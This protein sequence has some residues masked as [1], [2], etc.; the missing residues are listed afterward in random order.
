MNAT[1]YRSVKDL[2]PITD[3]TLRGG[4]GK[5]GRTFWYFDKDVSYEFGYGLSYT[6]FEYSHFKISQQ[7][8]HRRLSAENLS[9]KEI[10]KETRRDIAIK[11]LFEDK[12]KIEDIAI[13]RATPNMTILET[14]DATEVESVLDVVGEAALAEAIRQVWEHARSDRVRQYAELDLPEHI[15]LL[16]PLK[17]FPLARS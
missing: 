12:H 10:K 13:M 16:L 9:F 6:S 17:Y 7:V 5:N 4:D 15:A 1:W 3:Y 2:T 14:S 8:L 11:L